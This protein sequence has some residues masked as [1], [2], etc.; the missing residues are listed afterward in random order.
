MITP[1]PEQDLA[2]IG[3]IHGRADLLSLALARTAGATVVCVG[4]YIDRGPDSA[5]VLQMLMERPDIIAIGGNHESMLLSFLE[6]PEVY[7]PRWLRYGGIETLE[8]FSIDADAS[9]NFGA[10]RN[11]MLDGLGVSTVA[12]LRGLPSYWQSGNV[13]VVHAG[14]DPDVPMET[15]DDHSLRWGHPSFGR[16]PRRDGI[17]IVHGHTIVPEPRISDNCI[18]IDTGAY[19][20]DRL[21]VAHIP[22]RADIWFE[23]VGL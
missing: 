21:C 20:T 11:V 13:A 8:S 14:A 1:Q 16:Y 19:A 10:L 2:V 9:A 5:S 3:D 17:V 12:W 7:G 6:E 4:D 22:A 15:Q 18:A 23:Q